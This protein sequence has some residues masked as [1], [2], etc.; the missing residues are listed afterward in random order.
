[1]LTLFTIPKPF[2]GHISV[3]QR[4]A[5]QS[6]TRL[7][8]EIEVILF[9]ADEGAAE[10]AR[11]FRLR[12]E[13]Q[14]ARNEYGTILLHSVFAKAQQMA[15]YDVVCYVNCD[16]LLLD[17]FC[18]TLCTVSAAHN[19]FLMV[20][21][22]TDV[23]IFN[24]WPYERPTWQSEL[25]DFAARHGKIRPPN[26]IDYFG[27]SRG[28]YGPDL[29][30][31]A[32]GRTCW[33]DWL[34]WKALTSGKPVVDVSPV[35]LAVHQNHDYT[36]H[37]QGEPGV[38]KGLE[39]ARNSQLAGGWKNL[40]TIAHATEI[41]RADGLRPNKMRYWAETKRRCQ[42]AG[43]FFFYDVWQPVSFALLNWTRPLRTALGLRTEPVRPPTD[44]I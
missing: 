16:I 29:P 3:I 1:V 39:A 6:W 22:R 26:W 44:K 15:R 36:H 10:V 32:I 42:A 21:Q 9:G 13:P 40:R 38:F 17:D 7:H 18:S 28:L 5:I 20:G 4:N 19:E 24:P 37:P 43:R 31:F 8:P 14:A 41:L 25:R 30:P 23:D 12:H 2:K 33:D 34:V 35:V 27:F 11:E